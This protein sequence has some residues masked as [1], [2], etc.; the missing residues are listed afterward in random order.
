MGDAERHTRRSKREDIN[1][2]LLLFRWAPAT[3]QRATTIAS[4]ARG[5]ITTLTLHNITN[6]LNPARAL[7]GKT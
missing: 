1:I 2:I 4:I 3:L 6:G 5:N 7:Q